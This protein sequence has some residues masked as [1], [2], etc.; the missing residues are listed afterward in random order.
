MPQDSVYGPWPLSGEI[1]IA[2]VRGNDGST[3]LDGRDSVGSTLHWGTS[4]ATDMFYTTSGKHNIRRTDYSDDFHTY[5]LEWSQN[6]IFMYLDSRLLQVLYVG[7]GKSYGTMYTRGD[8]AALNYNDTLYVFHGEL[9][10]Q[11]FPHLLLFLTIIAEWMT[12]GPKPATSTHPS[13]K[14]ST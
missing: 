13:T 2:E 1:D 5:G 14:A 3:Y 7:F 11:I 4:A 8:F 12:H 10:N 6:Y 9:W